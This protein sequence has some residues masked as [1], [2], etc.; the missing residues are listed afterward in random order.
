[1]ECNGRM[2]HNG[3]SRDKS[4]LP[5]QEIMRFNQVEDRKLWWKSIFIGWKC[6]LSLRTS[7]HMTQGHLIPHKLVLKPWR[8]GVWFEESQNSSKTDRFC[9]YSNLG[10]SVVL[11]CLDNFRCWSSQNCSCRLLKTILQHANLRISAHAQMPSLERWW[12]STPP[13]S[14]TSD[15]VSTYTKPSK[16]SRTAWLEPSD[17]TA[18][19]SSCRMRGGSSFV[20]GYDM[21]EEAWAESRGSLPGQ[22]GRDWHEVR[23]VRLDWEFTRKHPLKASVFFF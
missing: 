18:I 12:H 7:A 15:A 3:F 19:W 21:I 22:F 1:M 16:R 13:S 8:Q 9:R 11:I 14:S 6:M 10:N 23:K 2:V 4:V 20:I 5:G 17:E